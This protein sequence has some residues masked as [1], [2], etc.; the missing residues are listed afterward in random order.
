MREYF[1][2][3]DIACAC[4]ALLPIIVIGVIFA[5]AV[6]AICPPASADTIILYPNEDRQIQREVAGSNFTSLAT[7]A[8]TFNTLDA[9]MGVIALGDTG[10][11]TY[12]LLRA[13]GVTFNSTILPTNSTITNASLTLAY[14]NKLNDQGT[15]SLVI[16]KFNP[17]NYL[18]IADNNNYQ[19]FINTSIGSISYASFSE[20]NN[21]IYLSDLTAVNKSGI[22]ALGVRLGWHVDQGATSP[23][24]ASGSSPSGF[25]F[26]TSAQASQDKDPFLTIVFTPA[27]ITPPAAIT[28]L[29][30]GTFNC[31]AQSVD[32]SWT[33][34]A[35]SDYYRLN[36]YING[37]LTYYGNASTS[38]TLS[39]L[40]ENTAMTF[41][42]RTEDL[43]G[44]LDPD[45]V[46][47]SFTTGTC[48]TPPVGSP[49]AAFTA[50][51]TCGSVPFYVQFTDTSAGSPGEW[52]WTS[53]GNYSDEQHPVFFYDTVGKYSVVINATNSFGSS[54]LTKTNYIRAVPE[55]Y[56][57]PP[58]TTAMIPNL[59][60]PTDFG[61]GYNQMLSLWWLALLGF[62]VL[63]LI[64]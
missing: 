30:N 48:A 11:N 6:I 37:T 12:S 15:P 5:L 3:Y 50:N 26:Y 55:W 17:A 47:L 38:T 44:N 42:T 21:T 51:V 18:S 31:P 54:Y 58:V 13:Y 63:R 16:T 14:S 61:E 9:I 45:W 32:I 27:D 40:P 20:G 10:A 56:E 24:W 2:L 29:A 59:P 57:C 41:N 36:A 62:V 60:A 23:T 33:N 46:N 28:N 34:P 43:L 35:D 7:G 39:G 49:T 8:G 1:S 4:L 64:T 52:N 22:T 25:Y 19:K 53:N